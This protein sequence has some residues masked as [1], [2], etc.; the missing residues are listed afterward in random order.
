MD[1]SQRGTHFGQRFISPQ[2]LGITLKE[3]LQFSSAKKN[4]SS[5]IS[6]QWK[7]MVPFVYVVTKAKNCQVVF[8]LSQQRLVNSREKIPSLKLSA[9]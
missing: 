4:V 1:A 9:A 6:Q 5:K 8:S 7:A 3:N 2:K